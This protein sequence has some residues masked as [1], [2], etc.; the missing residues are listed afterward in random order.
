MKMIMIE[1]TKADLANMLNIH[2]KM[3]KRKHFKLSSNL[4]YYQTLEESPYLQG[5]LFCQ[6]PEYVPKA[7]Y[8]KS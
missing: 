2:G 7:T 3:I 1:S 5:N 4:T 8:R 6:W